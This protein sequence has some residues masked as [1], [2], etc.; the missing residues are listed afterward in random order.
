[1]TDLATPVDYLHLKRLLEETDYPKTETE[2][3]VQGFRNGFSIGYAGP[4]NRRDNSSNIPF[5]V[6][7][8]TEMWNKLMSEVEANRIIGPLNKIPFDTYI[9][10]L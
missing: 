10:S 4:V 6:G 8:R 9:Q 1:M 5:T 2:F 7:N 3:L